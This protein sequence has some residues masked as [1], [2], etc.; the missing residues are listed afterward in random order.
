MNYPQCAPC[1]EVNPREET[2][3]P[4]GVQGRGLVPENT[5]SWIIEVTL[6]RFGYL[7]LLGFIGTFPR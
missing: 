6:T 1:A 2:I 5:G 3:A 7:Y 4:Q